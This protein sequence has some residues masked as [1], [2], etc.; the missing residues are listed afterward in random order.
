MQCEID[1]SN[2]VHSLTLLQNSVFG[3]VFS[4]SL[5]CCF[6]D[7]VNP[8]SL[9]MHVF[10]KVLNSFQL[11]LKC[12]C[13]SFE[14]A[15]PF[16]VVVSLQASYLAYFTNTVI[17]SFVGDNHLRTVYNQD[18]ERFYDIL[19]GTWSSHAYLSTA[20]VKLFD[21][22]EVRK[23]LFCVQSTCGF[24]A[25]N[26][27]GRIFSC[28]SHYIRHVSDICVT[29]FWIFK[30]NLFVKLKLEYFLEK[31]LNPVELHFLYPSKMW[32]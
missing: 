3:I 5:Y 28:D 19:V 14:L 21:H 30:N 22:Y 20:I 29:A 26:D 17:Y 16:H 4:V 13:Q 31:H 23:V 1:A 10:L 6:M 9:S 32:P 11:I 7:S 25:A 8:L 12:G 18:L 24:N 15:S 2:C 27:H